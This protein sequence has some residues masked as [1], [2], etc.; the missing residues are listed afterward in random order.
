MEVYNRPDTI[1]TM[2]QEKAEE[3]TLR[4]LIIQNLFIK[5]TVQHISARHR[6][7]RSN[8]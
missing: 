2:N 4:Q 5:H 3:S 8:E 1:E 7:Q 6:Y